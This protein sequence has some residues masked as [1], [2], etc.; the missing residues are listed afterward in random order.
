MILVLYFIMSKRLE[1]HIGLE[2]F[3]LELNLK[4]V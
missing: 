1:D 2:V 4:L 3:M